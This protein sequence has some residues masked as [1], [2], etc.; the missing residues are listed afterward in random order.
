MSRKILHGAVKPAF[1]FQRTPRYN[2]YSNKQ[3]WFK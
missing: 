1:F 3:Q 2:S